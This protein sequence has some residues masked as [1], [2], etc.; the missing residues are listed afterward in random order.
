MQRRQ[1]SAAGK[2]LAGH[3]MR[4]FVCRAGFLSHVQR[5]AGNGFDNAGMVKQDLMQLA[6]FM[7]NTCLVHA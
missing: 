1:R 4:V 3:S 5:F 6:A 7:V 2:A